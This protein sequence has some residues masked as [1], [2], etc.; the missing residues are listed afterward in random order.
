MP[1]S[2]A[3]FALKP[4]YFPRSERRIAAPVKTTTNPATMKIGLN[5][6]FCPIET[7]RRTGSRGSVQGAAIVS[8]PAR[9]AKKI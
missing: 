5:L 9:N 7:P 4:E 3:I 8:I 1:I 2:L 6:S